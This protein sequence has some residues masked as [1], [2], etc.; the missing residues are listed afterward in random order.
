MDLRI[1]N[2]LDVTNLLFFS[3]SYSWQNYTQKR[4][5]WPKVALC[6]VGEHTNYFTGWW[7][8]LWLWAPVW[9]LC[10][11]SF[12]HRLYHSSNG[13]L[14]LQRLPMHAAPHIWVCG[15]P[16]QIHNCHTKLSFWLDPIPQLW[17]S[18]GLIAPL[19]YAM[20]SHLSHPLQ[21]NILLY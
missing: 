1:A 6:M 19:L 11:P 7:A 10:M 8:R 3:F 17:H 16:C 5:V 4:W 20:N 12:M 14:Y 21:V 2:A 9:P 15:R 18:F 13:S